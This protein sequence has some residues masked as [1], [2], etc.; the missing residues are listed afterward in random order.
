LGARWP[1]QPHACGIHAFKERAEAD[2]FPATWEARRFA[3]AG[4]GNEY[5]IGQVSLWGRVVEYERGFRAELAYPYALLL[6]EN[7]KHFATRLAARYGIDV[8]V[9]APSR[10]T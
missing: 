7:Q 9:S 8:L 3:H 1:T 2:A 4:L 5:V 6:S 10:G